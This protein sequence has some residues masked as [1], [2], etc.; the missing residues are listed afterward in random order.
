MPTESRVKRWRDNKREQG[1]KHVSVWLTAEEE[2]RLK[3]LALQWHC[4][5]SQV[6]Q[7]ALAQV[8][9]T[10][11]PQNS[12]PTDTLLIRELI[13]DELAAMRVSIL[14][15]TVGDTVGITEGISEGYTVGPTDTVL[16]ER[17]TETTTPGAYVTTPGHS[18]ITEYEKRQ[19]PEADL[20]FD[21]A[22]YVLGKL[23]PEGHEWGTT[24]QSRLTINDRVCPECR[25]AAKR[26]KRAE[27]RQTTRQMA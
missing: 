15:V 21:P 26:R 10:T 19:S 8:A 22:K 1:L 9:T 5:P 16:H 23:C 11:P 4:S 24:G 7:R 6:M 2:M 13:R 14:P 12:S 3:D 25:N 18:V 27:K 17:G 20:G